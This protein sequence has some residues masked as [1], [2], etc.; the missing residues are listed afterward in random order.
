MSTNYTDLEQQ[1]A[2]KTHAAINKAVKSLGDMEMENAAV[3]DSP[4]GR[5]Q[6]LVSVYTSIK[7]L[8][9]VLTTL[10]IIPP[11]WRAALGFFV[12]TLEAVVAVAPQIS[13]DFKAGKDL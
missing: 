13:P 6:R 7:P 9:S 10:V 8:L 5:V 2:T 11:S 1:K 4:G 12:Q 3:T